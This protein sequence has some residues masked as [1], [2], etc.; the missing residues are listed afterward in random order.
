MLQCQE[1]NSGF[2][3][4]SLVRDP[5]DRIALDFSGNI[6]ALTGIESKLDE[7]KHDWRL[8]HPDWIND[9]YVSSLQQLR[10]E[11]GDR[12]M[13]Q[14]LQTS[15]VANESDM[16][17]IEVLLEARRRLLD[18][19]ASLRMDLLDYKQVNDEEERQV[20]ARRHDF[21]ARMQGFARLVDERA[22]R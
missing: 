22:K 13:Q 8:Q 3:L 12:V 6:V 7:F 4:L 1:D 5:L 10:M 16:D 19:Q 9:G 20:A 14:S 2:A 21:G 18:D 15:S 11:I 17:T